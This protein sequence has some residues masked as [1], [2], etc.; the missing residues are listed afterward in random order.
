MATKKSDFNAMMTMENIIVILEKADLL[1]SELIEASASRDCLEPDKINLLACMA[2]DYIQ[3]A[4]SS[5]S[6]Y[7]HA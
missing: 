2:Q 4:H 3:K 5:A 6:D 1:A 7:V